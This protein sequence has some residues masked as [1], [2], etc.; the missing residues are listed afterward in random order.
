[1]S[2]LL[3]IL[4]LLLAGAAHAHETLPASLMLQEQAAHE[5]DVLWRLPAAQGTAPDI[6]PHLPAD[7]A[8]LTAPREEAPP[9]ARTLRWR[10]RCEGG[11]RGGRISFE[12]LSASMIDVLVHVG[13]ADGASVARV[14][15]PRAPAADLSTEAPR[16]VAAT[17]YFALGV[18]H[19]LG[20]IDHLLFVLCL[21]L[22]VPGRVA[23]LKTITAFTLAHSLT[24]AA[25]ALG[26]VQVPQ[27]P[28]E[29]TIALSIVFVARELARG[30]AALA[31]RRPWLVAFAF[32]LLHGFGFAGAL[33]E[34]GLPHG[35][36]PL[37]LA[38]FN[39]GVEAGQ[40][41]FVGAV[42]GLLALARR[43][44]WQPARWAAQLPVYAIGAV[45]AS[46]WLQRMEL[47]GT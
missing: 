7:C 30:Q 31:A 39:V 22:L 47:L 16:A 40:I 41:L 34:V 10:V 19:I 24:L 11:L 12:G 42:L 38:L 20:G 6:T 4:A 18:E 2:R 43:I 3:V 29:A 37:A 9:A 28:V 26:A 17:G 8:A 35:E 25:S 36:V 45:A 27:A 5:F 32:G 46:W 15:R 33:A 44:R 14:A 13:F 21:M 1:M 23:L